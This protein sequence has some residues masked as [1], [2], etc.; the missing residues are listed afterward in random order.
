MDQSFSKLV[1]T[2]Q[3]CEGMEFVL[4]KANVTLGRATINE[5]VLLHDS[6]VSRH[7]ARIDKR[8]A[9]FA[10]MD[11][12]ST[13]GTYVNGNRVASSALSP[14]DVIKLG[15]TVFRFE[16]GLP[17]IEPDV[18]PLDS[19]AD[20]EKTLCRTTL[21]MTLKDTEIPRF[22]VHTPGKTWEVSMAGDA[23]SIGRHPQSDIVLDQPMV[24]RHHA[25]IE[26]RGEKF[27]IRDL[28]SS[29]GTFV[30][31]KRMEEHALQDCDAILI[32]N[33]RLVFKHKFS[34]ED[35]TLT[36]LPKGLKKVTRHPVIFVP[37]LTGSELWR[38][39]ERV[40]PN[41]KLFF[42]QPQQLRLSED[43][44]LE[45]RAVVAEV[46]VVPNLIKLDRYSRLG[47]YLEESLGY[48]RGKDLFEFPYD[49]RQ[50][51]RL[52]AKELA[53]AIDSWKI[54][55]RVVIIAHSMGSLVS[56][57]YVERLGGK[58]KVS[59]MIFLGGPHYGAP[60]AL[61]TLLFGPKLLPFGLLGER[62]RQVISTFPS[63]YQLLPI[64]PCAED[65]KKQSIDLLSDETWLL[66]EQRPLLRTAREFRKEL[67]THCSVPS[68][69]IFGYG[70]K[71][72]TRVKVKRNPQGRWQN[73]DFDVEEGGDA[74][75][76]EQ[77]AIVE[78]SEIHPVQQAHGSLYVDR[79]V[80]KRLKVELTRP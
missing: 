17:Q 66:E 43:N 22:A 76:P 58:K 38:G 44:P 48:E 16:S 50:D 4:E 5:I 69:S 55:P 8:G 77:S 51:C 68:I 9:G 10:I 72:V 2:Q 6:K 21:S 74:T 42:T 41:P 79:D 59:R 46:V 40:W 18:I 62:L 20:L 67:G 11:L 60:K 65:Q 25:R 64:Y 23:L 78:G 45:A 26:K 57:Y 24:S 71:T 47:D 49:W 61:M 37:G 19:E 7:H 14:G 73:V 52:A 34:S 29:N 3:D 31:G 53:K 33:A 54:S 15:D 70:I 35:L 12:G 13:N 63:M 32:G 1:L 27:I 80:K 56:R 75:V 30:G 28:G 39:S 36:D